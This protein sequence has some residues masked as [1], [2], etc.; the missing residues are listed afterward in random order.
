MNKISKL[1]LIVF[2][3]SVFSCSKARPY[4][5]SCVSDTSAK[6]YDFDVKTSGEAKSKCQDMTTQGWDTCYI[7]MHE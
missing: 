3:F 2:A 5:C 7:I 4:L 6:S 1:L